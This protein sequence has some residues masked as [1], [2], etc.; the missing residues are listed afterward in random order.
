MAESL[1]RIFVDF[2]GVLH[3]YESSYT[4]PSEIKDGPVV[5]SQTGR[6]AI[7]WL[8]TLLQS[9]HFEVHIFSRR[10]SDPKSGGVAEN[11]RFI[12]RML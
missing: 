7:A 5:D 4:K 9:G 3:R 2:D 12:T 6:D 10:C 11:D 1:K 8:T